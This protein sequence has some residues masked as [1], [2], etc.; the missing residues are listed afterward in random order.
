MPT[1]KKCGWKNP[2]QTCCWKKKHETESL[3]YNFNKIPQLCLNGAGLDFHE[4]ETANIL[5]LGE[6]E[7][8]YGLSTYV[9]ILHI[10]K[11][12]WWQDEWVADWLNAWLTNWLPGGSCGSIYVCVRECFFCHPP[13]WLLDIFPVFPNTKGYWVHTHQFSSKCYSHT[14]TYLHKHVRAL[15]SHHLQREVVEGA[16]HLLQVSAKQSAKIFCEQQI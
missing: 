3:R 15:Q 14:H 11:C 9:K 6:G 2:N 8:G 12:P 4:I 10:H 7:M 13:R 1:E 5:F 16:S